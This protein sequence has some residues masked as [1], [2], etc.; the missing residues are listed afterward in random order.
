M[1]LPSA[2]RIA[3][4]R[5]AVRLVVFLTL[6]AAVRASDGIAPLVRVSEPDQPGSSARE[7]AGEMDFP[8]YLAE[9]AR[10]STAVAELDKHPTGIPTLRRSL[11][12]AWVVRV[13]GQRFEVPAGWLDSALE[14]M[15][16]NP[17]A[18]ASL[19]KD[20]RNRVELLKWQAQALV[21]ADGG[22]D[23]AAAA[24]RL[25]SILA[26]REFRAVHGPSWWDVLKA[27]IS[28][29][30][31]EV[32]RKFFSKLGMSR[33][34]R[35]VVAWVLIA[36][37]FVLLALA[38]WRSL[39]GVQRAKGLEIGGAFSPGKT[40]RDWGQEALAAAARHDYR[41]AL[42]AAYW[43]GVYRLADLGAWQLDRA[44]TPREYLRL[45][46]GQTAPAGELV[47]SGVLPPANHADRAA[48]LA[49]L[50]RGL[51][52]TWYGYQLATA[53][54]FRAALSQLEA[55]GCRFSS[56]LVTANS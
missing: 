42:H 38:V 46:A 27:R 2:T 52:T 22:P 50:T 36:L 26:R 54:D 34:T 32:L 23:T 12:K 11:P 37:A 19:V 25:E 10:I 56:N 3:K 15:A 30:V 47:A 31:Y 18:R 20:V 17:A 35:E 55:L 24:A 4:P 53:D 41:A 8:G 16:T 43:A 28:R 7:T 14:T 29:W 6:V 39:L 51:E 9:L 21:R 40:W 5:A 44:R 49:A 1:R 45:F 48:A 33:Q 13:A